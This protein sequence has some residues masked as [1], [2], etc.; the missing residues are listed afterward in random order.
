MQNKPNFPSAQMNV[1]NTLTT[2]Y[3]N[4][5][6][7]SPLQNKPNLESR[8]AGN[9]THRP[10]TIQPKIN[11]QN[12]PNYPSTKMNLTTAL[13]KDYQNIHPHSP[14]QYKPDFTP[15]PD[16]IHPTIKMQNKPNFANDKINLTT[17]GSRS[18]ENM[19]VPEP[20]TNKANFKEPQ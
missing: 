19:C 11:M 5:H 17:Y 6:P 16:S 7:R 9:G 4:T 3:Q 12:K 15:I 14:L 8:R 18:Y 10:P 1:S 20:R 2:D 13:T